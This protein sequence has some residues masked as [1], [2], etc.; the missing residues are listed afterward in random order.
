MG[1]PR[2]TGLLIPDRGV[3]VLTTDRV[4]ADVR[5]SVALIGVLV[6]AL[7]KRL[8]RQTVVGNPVISHASPRLSKR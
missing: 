3:V 1:T 4:A 2:R 5:K 6:E 7:L 8:G